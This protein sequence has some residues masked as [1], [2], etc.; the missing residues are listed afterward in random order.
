M[1]INEGVEIE[2]TR[3]DLDLVRFRRGS[4]ADGGGYGRGLVRRVDFE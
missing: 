2:L 3:H 4:Q 1:N